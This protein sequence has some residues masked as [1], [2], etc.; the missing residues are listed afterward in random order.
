MNP[1]AILAMTQLIRFGM[2]G[3]EAMQKGEKTPEEVMA[4]YDEMVK[5]VRQAS[6]RW[7]KA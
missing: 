5:T 3:I 1:E 4:D 6:D 7:R 2:E